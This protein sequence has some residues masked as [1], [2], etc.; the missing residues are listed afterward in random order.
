MGRVAGVLDTQRMG[1]VA[2]VKEVLWHLMEEDIV[3]GL[4]VPLQSD[5][6]EA[7]APTLIKSRERLDRA[8]PLAPVMTLNSAKIAALLLAQ[9]TGK[10]L[11]AVLRP[12]ESRALMEL[13]RQGRVSLEN[14]VMVSV[15]CLGSHAES[16]YEQR[17][18]LWGDEVPVRESLRWSRRGQIAA[19]RFRRAC[20]MCEDPYFDEASIV[21]GLFGQDLREQIL[22]SVES[23]LAERMGF[24][25]NGWAQPS[26]PEHLR[27]REETIQR[28]LVQR[29]RARARLLHELQEDLAQPAD[30]LELLSACTL[31]GECQKVCPLTLVSDFD[32]GAYTENTAEYAAARLLEMV[33]R[34]DFCAGC[35]MCEAVCRAD[36]PLMLLV[37]M[38]SDRPQIRSSIRAALVDDSIQI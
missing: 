18:A 2:A 19:Y 4:L 13:A 25:R 6:Q 20:Q 36:L 3:Q 17:L 5:P 9:E 23:D 22:I 37:Q 10:R 26:A 14:L 32:I 24:A 28:L 15:D 16:D 7:P 30:V 12:C 33:R 38:L 21:V 8:N 31:C 1:A 27:R 35:G 11:A 34:S 29:R